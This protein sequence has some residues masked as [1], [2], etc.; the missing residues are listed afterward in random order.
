MRTLVMVTVATAVVGCV[1]EREAFRADALDVSGQWFLTS[2]TIAAAVVDVSVE[3]D[4]ND[5]RAVL[6]RSEDV[7]AV[8]VDEADVVARLRNV[9]DRLL[10]RTALE[11]GTGT[12]AVRTELVGGENVSFDGG[13]TASVD[14]VSGAYAASTEGDD[15]L[16]RWGVSLTGNDDELSGEL[17]V[18]ERRRTHTI[19]TT[20]T[21]LTTQRSAVEITLTRAR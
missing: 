6:R 7:D 13:S 18:T 5:I 19:G 4:L 14:V 9:N 12:D 3:T 8:S 20:D 11:L 1:D 16:V 15:S 21:D 17:F 2:P 10:V